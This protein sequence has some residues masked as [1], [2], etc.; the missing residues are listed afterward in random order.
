MKPEAF[1]ERMRALEYFHGLR[2]LPGAWTVI[3]LDG[4]GFTRF[5]A[6]RFTKPF[7]PRFRDLMAQI[8]QALLLEMHAIYAYTESDEIS[9]LFRP[10]WDLFDRELEKLLSI[11]AGIAAASFTHAVGIPAH[12]DSRV[13]LGV[14]QAVV[15]DYFRWRQTDAARCALHGWAYWTLRQT[16]ANA[17]SATAQLRGKAADYLNELLFQHGINFNALPAWQRRGTGLYWEE[18]EKEGFNPRTGQAVTA[19]RRRIKRDEELPM[20]EEYAGFLER[21]MQPR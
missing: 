1:E 11:S 10:E 6:G 4:R 13:W 21:L 19:T 8:A 17:A 3:R 2:L 9:L 20:K 18:Y 12:F 16:G 14:D 7:D 15:T 5:T